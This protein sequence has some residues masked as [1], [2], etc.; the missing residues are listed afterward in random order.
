MASNSGKRTSQ[1]FSKL[2]ASLKQ[3]PVLLKNPRKRWRVIV[4][5]L[6]AVAVI[7]GG[8]Y[9]YKAIYLPAH[10]VQQAAVQTT[11]A[12][13]GDIVLSTTGTGTLQAANQADLAFKTSG[14]LTQVNVKVGD[15]VKQGA[16]LAQLDNTSQVLAVQQAQQ[17]LAGQTNTAAV[18][19][20]QQSIAQAEL[21]LQTAVLQ[22]QYLISP[23]VYYWEN[24]VAADQQAVKDAQAAVN[25]APTDT[26]AQAKL[27][28]AQDTLASAQAHLVG[29][30]ASYDKT[31]VPNNF[32]YHT[33]NK[34]THR[35]E[36][37]ISP[38]S[39]AD[40][41]KARSAVTVAQGA[42]TDAQN[43]YATLT[44]GDVPDNA[45]GTGLSSLQQAKVALQTAQ[46]NLQ[47]TQITAPF[48]GTV[49]AVD[50]QVGDSVGT[51]TVITLAD[52]STLYLQTYVDQSDFSMFKT[53]NTASIVFDALPD[54]TYT[55]KVVEVSPALDTSSGSAVVSGLVQLDTTSGSPSGSNS[56]P[57]SGAASDPPSTNLL[58][59]MTASVNVIAG[60][61]Q[62][63]VL[64]PVTALHE[65]SPGKYAVFVMRNGKLA[66]D[67]VTVG[68]QDPVNAEIKSGLQPGDIVS[69]GLVT[70]KTT[71]T[72]T[73]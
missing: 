51:S 35:N 30:Q 5:A 12:R 36:K 10:S 63:A 62:N 13:R 26:A 73:P 66:V 69:T 67:F 58:I 11:V 28:Q 23:P 56:D 70:T 16:V 48:S 52:M 44:G 37:Y 60:Q 34:V 38:P 24:Q 15:Q 49:V 20:A 40:V 7:G 18:A 57:A 3:L 72:T 41:L 50:A 43:L 47:A 19:S 17:T 39:A 4:P 55:G 31:Y 42:L 59:G 14:K 25:A 45:S 53:G 8:Y 29:A 65:Y 9:Y 64:I 54:Q 27:K 22:L 68:L 46:D 33:V 32:V 71:T 61:A 21:D 2:G 6:V 1:P